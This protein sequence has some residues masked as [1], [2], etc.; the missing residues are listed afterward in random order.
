V[1]EESVLWIIVLRSFDSLR[2]LRMTEKRELRMT[3]K[4]G[5]CGEGQKKLY[6]D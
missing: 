6:Y 3:V 4:R 2:S 1:V 5:D